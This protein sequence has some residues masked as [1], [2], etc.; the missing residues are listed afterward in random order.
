[1]KKFYGWGRKKSG[2]KAVRL[3]SLTENSKFILREDGFIRSIGIGLDDHKSFS[4]SHRHN[5][6]QPMFLYPFS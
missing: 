6:L 4:A 5:L 1:M 2:F 3:A